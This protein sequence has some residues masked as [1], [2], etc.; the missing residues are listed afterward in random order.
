M[1]KIV[2]T[3]M[4]PASVPTWPIRWLSASNSGLS[5]SPA[6]RSRSASAFALRTCGWKKPC[7]R[8]KRAMIAMKP[9]TTKASLAVPDA[10]AGREQVDARPAAGR[11]SPG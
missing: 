11:S 4:I 9:T 7:W 3:T 8:P 6:F 2:T 10:V 5:V 1:K